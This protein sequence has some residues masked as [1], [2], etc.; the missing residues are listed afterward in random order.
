MTGVGVSVF[1]KSLLIGGRGTLKNL[2]GGRGL[3]GCE[4]LWISNCSGAGERL[5][6]E[7]PLG[8]ES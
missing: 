8:L 5:S 4:V 3:Q 1:T 2:S 7:R 6:L